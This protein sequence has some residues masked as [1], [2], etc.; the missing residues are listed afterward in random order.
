MEKI[1]KPFLTAFLLCVINCLLLLPAQFGLNLLPGTEVRPASFFPVFAGIYWGLP[2]AIGIGLGNF[3]ADWIANGR[4]VPTFLLG[5]LANFFYAYIPYKCWYTFK[6]LLNKK[7]FFIH[8]VKSLVKYIL[9]ALAACVMIALHVSIVLEAYLN[10]PASSNFLFLFM[11]NFEFCMVLG[12]PALML[13]PYT[14]LKPFQPAHFQHGKIPSWAC[15]LAGFLGIAIMGCYFLYAK[16]T[17]N[18]TLS[19]MVLFVSMGLLALGACKKIRIIP[20]AQDDDG[21]LKTSVKIRIFIYCLMMALVMTI[22][23]GLIV[24]A[25]LSHYETDRM[26]LWSHVY[27]AIII[28]LNLILFVS[29]LLLWVIEKQITLPLYLLAKRVNQSKAGGN[30]L[31]ILHSSLEFVVTASDG[32][33]ASEDE[34]KLYIGLNDGETNAPVYTAAQAREMVGAICLKHVNGYTATEGVGG[35]VDQKARPVYESTLIYTIFGASQQ[36]IK[37]ICDDILKTLNQNAILIEKNSHS[38][39]YYFGKDNAR[40]N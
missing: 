12:L 33:A 35:W 38:R 14:R 5:S 24:Y 27:T 30:E 10:L 19:Y 39:E 21:L 15:D 8:D 9:I 13:L 18:Q 3:F 22:A 34:Y 16:G 28:S 40:S 17:P 11:N 25:I 29:I 7:G 31:D 6:P 20:Q 2:G 1:K 36:Q 37:T 4:I 23:M 26:T 32:S